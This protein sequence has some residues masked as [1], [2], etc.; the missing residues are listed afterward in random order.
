[1]A[2]E[3]FE[4]RSTLIEVRLSAPDAH[5][6]V[7]HAAVFD[8]RADIMGLFSEQIQK[9]AFRKALKGVD[10][11]ALWNHDQN[12]LLGRTVAKT[13]RLS[14]DDRGLAFEL[15]LPDTTRGRDVLT[16]VQR[17]DI[18]GMSFAFTVAREKWDHTENLRTI[19]EVDRLLDVSP[20]TNPAYA[21]T[22]LALRSRGEYL[23]AE[24]R[25]RVSRLRN[26]LALYLARQKEE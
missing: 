26:R 21:G 19:V 5:R 18:R 15:D 12:E 4:V 7:G 6:L 20:V 1:M 2:T 13:L 14:E 22:D 10:V 11:V 23:A 9:G 3:L 25:E 24:Q 8:Q 16:L 17:G